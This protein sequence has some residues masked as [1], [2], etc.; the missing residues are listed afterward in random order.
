MAA[1]VFNCSALTLPAASFFHVLVSAD[2][3]CGGRNWLPQVSPLE[4]PSASTHA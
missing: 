3:Y 2:R 1:S 4:A